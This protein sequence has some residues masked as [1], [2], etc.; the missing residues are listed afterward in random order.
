MNSNDILVANEG[1]ELLVIKSI[2]DRIELECHHFHLQ[3]ISLPRWQPFFSSPTFFHVRTSS[4]SLSP[5]P[6]RRDGAATHALIPAL[7][8]SIHHELSLAAHAAQA[9]K[10]EQGY[11]GQG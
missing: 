11:K 4:P 3:K 1:S 5:L 2:D 8:L 7:D 6:P 10:R 9:L